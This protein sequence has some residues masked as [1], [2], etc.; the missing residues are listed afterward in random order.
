[1]LLDLGAVRKTDTEVPLEWREFVAHDGGGLVVRGDDTAA[2][3]IFLTDRAGVLVSDRIEELLDRMRAGGDEP[4]V[5]PFAVSALISSGLTPPPFSEF[6]GI[7]ALTMGDVAHVSWDSGRPR[8]V[9]SIDYPWF[10][11]RSRQDNEPSE[12]KLLDLLTA[13]TLRD[14]DAAGGGG[15]LMLSSGKDSAAVALALAEAGRTDIPCVTYSSGPDDPEPPVAADI[16]RRLGLEHRVVTLPHDRQR[17][18]AI[19]TRFFE[20]SPCPGPDLKQ[21]PYVLA[22]AGAGSAGGIVI[23]GGGNDSYMGYPVTSK[24][25]A[26]TR[27]RLR[28]RR[29]IDFV[30]RHIPVDS[31]VNY[32]ARSRLETVLAGRLPRFHETRLFYPGAVD[33]RDFWVKLSRDSADLSLF[34]VY[35]LVER[36]VTPP[37]SMR[38][39]LLAARTIGHQASVPWCDREVADYYFNLPEQYRYD[40]KHG[41]NKVLLREMLLRYLD[42]DADKVGKHYFSFEGDRFVAENRELVKSEIDSCA[43]WDRGNL[44]IV[45]DWIDAIDRRPLLHH[46]ILTIFMVSGWHNHSRVGLDRGV[47]DA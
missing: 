35:A 17:V 38:K 44:G 22:T 39:H 37:T 20:A 46:A 26:K 45:H 28:N 36:Y 27:L 3:E 12:R 25:A 1:M 19:L 9:F 23:D 21:I 18:A 24:Y 41:V 42:Y 2:T 30:Q 43:L 16:C 11:A 4:V 15:F 7:Y 31:P 47:T 8:L 29:L 40:R 13:A 14:L 10:A 34:D 33:V 32:I 6:A 5:S